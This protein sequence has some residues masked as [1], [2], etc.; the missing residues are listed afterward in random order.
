[1]PA[2]TRS[3]AQL[4]EDVRAVG[5]RRGRGGRDVGRHRRR[6]VGHVLA[7]VAVV[8][9]RLAVPGREHRLAELAHLGTEVVEVVL[10]RHPLAARLEHAAE[11]IAD[12]RA[13]RVADVQ[14]P[15]RVGRHEL[16]VDGAR[17]V[18]LEPAPRARGREDPGHGRL[19]RRVR[20]P[21]VHE[22]R[23]RDLGRGDQRAVGTR[24]DRVGQRLGDVQ[25][26]PP[27][28]PRELHRE[29]GG[30][31]AERRVRGTLDGDSGPLDSVL[32]RGQRPRPDGR[33]PRPGHGVA[34]LRPDGGRGGAGLAGAGHGSSPGGRAGKRH[35]SG[36]SAARRTQ[37]GPVPQAPIR[38][39][40]GVLGRHAGPRRPACPE[41][42]ARSHRI[43]AADP[44]G[45]VTVGRLGL[46]IR[47]FGKYFRKVGHG[48]FGSAAHHGAP[49]LTLGPRD[50]DGTHK[51]ECVPSVSSGAQKGSRGN[52]P[53]CPGRGTPAALIGL[54][55]SRQAAATRIGT[56]L[57]GS[58][59][60]LSHGG[61]ARPRR[62]EHRTT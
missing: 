41:V 35:R 7:V 9:Y 20:Q 61:L 24:A 17:L 51:P 48:T 45:W 5:S 31:I 55:R 59:A 50:P 54:S 4:P 15:G 3:E 58:G 13:P 19:E 30:E 11:E 1:M 25:R 26:R 32:D 33:V 18:G 52:D 16:D 60:Q 27:Q 37:H 39:T 12:E 49:A 10:A 28:R 56:F 14:R 6:E 21:Q 53:G 42:V 40:T 47:G 57:A 62:G 38:P 22:P 43:G 34:H 29:V 23:P 46:V 2:R 36:S 44:V 8:R